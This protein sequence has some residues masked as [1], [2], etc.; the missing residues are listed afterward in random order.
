M[1]QLQ[2]VLCDMDGTLV[3]SEPYWAAAKT[4]IMAQYG[5]PF[6][7]E[8]TAPLVGKSMMFTVRAMQAA[9]LPLSDAQTVVALVEHV[10]ARVQDQLP[11][12]PDAQAFLRQ[13]KAENVP[14][15]LVTQGW[16][17]IAQLVVDASD[18]ALRTMVTGDEVVNPKPHPEPYLTAAARLGV[19][20]TYCVAIEDSPTG[21]D[22][23]EAAGAVVIALPGIHPMPDGDHRVRLPSLRGVDR[24]WLEQLLATRAVQG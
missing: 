22:S 18:G 5:I 10:A 15:A 7:P 21:V 20:P 12:L 11:W 16:P 17:E 9:G 4:E 13:M 3:D 19:D 23:A 2:G 8:Q 6:T 1:S 14:C 24:A